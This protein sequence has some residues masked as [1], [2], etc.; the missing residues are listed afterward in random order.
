MATNRSCESYV[1]ACIRH[2]QSHSQRIR[3]TN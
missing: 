3:R 2:S 1:H